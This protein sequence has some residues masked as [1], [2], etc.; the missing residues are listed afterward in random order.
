MALTYEFFLARA[1]D[2]ANEANLAVLENV[3]ERA[4]RSEAAWRGMADKALKAANGREAALRE[5]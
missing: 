4:L 3:R 5:K 2:A 1:Q